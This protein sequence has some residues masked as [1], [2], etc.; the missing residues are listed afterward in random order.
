MFLIVSACSSTHQSSQSHV[1]SQ[2][3]VVASQDFSQGR[4]SFYDPRPVTPDKPKS[5][6]A[7]AL[8][9]VLEGAVGAVGVVAQSQL[10]SASSSSGSSYNANTP[11]AQQLAS[12]SSS[13]SSSSGYNS[14]SSN[15]GATQTTTQSTLS[16]AQPDTSMLAPANLGAANEQVTVAFKASQYVTGVGIIRSDYARTKGRTFGY[17]TTRGTIQGYNVRGELHTETFEAM[18]PSKGP[19]NNVQ[20][21]VLG[22]S[23]FS[24][25]IKLVRVDWVRP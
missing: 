11:A 19:Y 20:V 15:K 21:N 9:S 23:D 7:S 4:G 2:G 24:R 8:G 16:S 6:F 3:F 1:N 22:A 13:N 17:V 14:G 12:N 18:F 5:A 10:N 25:G